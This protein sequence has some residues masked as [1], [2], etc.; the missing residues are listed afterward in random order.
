MIR[1]VRHLIHPLRRLSQATEARCLPEEENKHKTLARK[2]TWKKFRG[3][4]RSNYIGFSSYLTTFLYYDFKKQ[5]L[6][7]SRGTLTCSELCMKRQSL[8]KPLS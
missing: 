8:P 3:K 7:H 4:K 2:Q 1:L 5:N 6:P